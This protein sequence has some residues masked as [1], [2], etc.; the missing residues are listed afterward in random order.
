[1]TSDFQLLMPF[2]SNSIHS[3]HRVINYD[4]CSIKL[5]GKKLVPTDRVK[6]LGIYI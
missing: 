4:K 1:M 6:Y 3:N 5:N 2:K